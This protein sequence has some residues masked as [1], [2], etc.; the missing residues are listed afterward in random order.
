MMR[1]PLRSQGFFHKKGLY[2]QTSATVTMINTNTSIRLHQDQGPIF[3]FQMSKS[4]KSGKQ[5]HLLE[6]VNDLQI[7]LIKQPQLS[8]LDLAVTT[9]KISLAKNTSLKNLQ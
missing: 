3:R 8:T 2:R 7:K 1:S 5:Q 9:L 4:S 6:T